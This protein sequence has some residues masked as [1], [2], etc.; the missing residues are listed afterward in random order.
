MVLP[1]Q[2]KAKEESGSWSDDDG[3][4]EIQLSRES[5]GV[6]NTRFGV[7]FVCL[8]GHTQVVVGTYASSG[9]FKYRAH[10]LFS[11]VFPTSFPNQRCTT[12]MVPIYLY[13]Q[14]YYTQLK[15]F[16]YR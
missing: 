9:K 11:S 15:P 4:F 13:S 5:S 1:A 6:F 12:M 7:S 2:D 16:Y 14:N 8:V 10:N 3:G